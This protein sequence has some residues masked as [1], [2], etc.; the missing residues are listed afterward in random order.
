MKQELQMVEESVSITC[1]HC[2]N[3]TFTARYDDNYC[4]VGT[5][6]RL[7]CKT[8]DKEMDFKLTGEAPSHEKFLRKMQDLEK[9]VK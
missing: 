5:A 3:K 2:L 8:C 9:L 4:E 1:P 7:F 6:L